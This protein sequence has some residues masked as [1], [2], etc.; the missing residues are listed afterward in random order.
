MEA[1]KPFQ[2]SFEDFNELKK[3]IDKEVMIRQEQERVSL[4]NTYRITVNSRRGT[5]RPMGGNHAEFSL[6]LPVI[7]GTE[8]CDCAVRIRGFYAPIKTRTAHSNIVKVYTDFL[9]PKQYNSEHAVVGDGTPGN[10]LQ[11]QQAGL[12]GNLLG[13][14]S[15]QQKVYDMSMNANAT[16]PVLQ[17]LKVDGSIE[18]K[19]ENA[20]AEQQYFAIDAQGG[21][22]GPSV[23]ATANPGT[24]ILKATIPNTGEVALAPGDQK[25]YR[26][27]DDGAVS[28]VDAAT[29][30]PQGRTIITQFPR[31]TDIKPEYQYF[32]N[33]PVLLGYE[34]KPLTNDW[35]PCFNPF[36]RTISFKLKKPSQQTN[37]AEENN[38]YGTQNTQQVIIELEVRIFPDYRGMK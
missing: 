9:K 23:Q 26:V 24:S 3:E 8:N 21:F 6:S 10:P 17:Y 20:A 35:L 38:N 2:R 32:R 22:I 34:G 31:F 15:L 25:F 29:A 16:A 19:D 14:V 28:L 4:N 7:P 36:G 33:K 12:S 13:L 11:L 5:S 30:V 18:D 37:G 1:G 27:L